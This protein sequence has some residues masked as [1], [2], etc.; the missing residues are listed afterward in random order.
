MTRIARDIAK[1][2]KQKGI[3]QDWYKE[4]RTLE[5][6]EQLA[7][8][9]LKGIDFCLTNDFPSNDVLRAKFK[10]TM[11]EYGIHLDEVFGSLNG[12]KVVALGSCRAAVEIDE[13]HVSE[14]FVKHT[15]L[16]NLTAKDCAF[17]MVDA[18]ENTRV[19]IK[20]YGEA[21]VVVNRYGNAEVYIIE[22]GKNARV[23]IVD[24]NKI[25]Y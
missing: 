8:M 23:K 14:V 24:K 13:H 6:V 21:R 15:S 12:R 25:T 11:E 16:L 20:A 17:V 4:L 18:F 9:Y 19:K 1:Q 3:C 10:G 2:A 5:T 22:K 7:E